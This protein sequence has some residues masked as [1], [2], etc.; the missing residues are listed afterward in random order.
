[1]KNEP[2]HQEETARPAYRDIPGCEN[3]VLLPVDRSTM[4]ARQASFLAHI[5]AARDRQARERIETENRAA[6]EIRE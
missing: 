3:L 4:A 1:M 6:Q 2:L 5:L